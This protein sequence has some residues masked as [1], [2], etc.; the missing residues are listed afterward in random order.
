MRSRRYGARVGAEGSED[1]IFVLKG[2]PTAAALQEL[3]GKRG[4][5]TRVINSLADLGG[6]SGGV[7]GGV[8]LVH[9]HDLSPGAL[10]TIRDL[11]VHGKVHVIGVISHTPR[12]INTLALIMMLSDFVR[13]PIDAQEL[14]VRLRRVLTS[15]PAKAINIEDPAQLASTGLPVLPER[16]S[17]MKRLSPIERNILM[18]L[19]RQL[20][21]VVEI[22]S[23]CT[24]VD[25]AT[26]QQRV[27]AVR[28]HISR[29]RRKIEP[30]Y[31]RPEYI[32]NVR[33]RG[34]I[35]TRSVKDA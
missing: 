1:F 31:R 4:Y 11:Q 9:L 26:H 25:G 13:M 16:M 2:D 19:E 18:L 22:E 32:I 33:S 30:D 24:L 28:V 27:S 29:L 10:A 7:S 21:T 23:L 3:V 5:R 20:N 6:T 34:Y 12:S 15:G 35:L 17:Y 8:L 14:D